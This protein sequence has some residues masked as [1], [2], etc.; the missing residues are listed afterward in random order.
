MGLGGLALWLGLLAVPA[1][2]PVAFV[3]VSDA[4]EGQTARL[5]ATTST[6]ALAFIVIGSAVRSNTVAGAA[7]PPLVMWALVAALFAYSAPAFAW[8]LEPVQVS[9]TK[10]Q[11][12]RR[13][14]RPVVEIDSVEEVFERAA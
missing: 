9:R 6:L 12:R 4:L 1:A 8:M 5:S 14:P 10:P 11:R 13:R 2:A 7:T 3:A